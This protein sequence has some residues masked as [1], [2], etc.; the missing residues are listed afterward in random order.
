MLFSKSLPQIRVEHSTRRTWR[1]LARTLRDEVA[2][3]WHQNVAAEL[4]YQRFPAI[5]AAA[6]SQVAGEPHH[7]M[8]P[9]GECWRAGDHLSLPGLYRD[10]AGDREV[11]LRQRCMRKQ[12][13]KIPG[14]R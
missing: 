3:V 12:E 7:A 11:R 13:R 4:F 6:W 14:A 9:F 5:L 10:G 2:H 1:V 8:G